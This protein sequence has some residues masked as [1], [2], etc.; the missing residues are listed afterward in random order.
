MKKVAVILGL[1][2]LGAAVNAEEAGIRLRFGLND[3]TPTNWDG[4][5]TVS[6]GHVTNI[7]GWRFT[8]ADS[9]DGYASWQ[10]ATRPA[11]GP[12]RANNPNA[13]P[14]LNL[15]ANTP[16]SDNGVLLS[17]A[18]VTDDSVVDV[19][20]TQGEFSFKLGDVAYGKIVDELDSAVEVERTASAVTLT[21]AKTDDDYPSAALA[22]DGTVFVAY[23][24]FT[25][26]LDR[27]QR[28]RRLESAPTD[29][30]FLS[31][32]PGGDQL[33]LR[34]VDGPRKG[35]PVAV[36]TTGHDIYKS[37]VAVDGSGTVWI[38][39][40]ENTAYQPFPNNPLPNFD[41]WA[42]PF[43]NGELGAPQQISS[44]PENDVW[45]VATTDAKGRV[46]VAW[47]GAR[48]QIF[49]IFERH[50]QGDGW[51]DERQVS[52]QTR[53][54]WAPAIAAASAKNGGRV[55][56]GWD[57]YDQGDYDVWLREF[58]ADAQ[59]ADARPV[60]NSPDYEARPALTY[61]Q[62]GSLWVAYELSGPSWGKDWGALVHD[63]GIPLYRDRQI[64]LAVLKDGQWEQP[65]H[66][67]ENALPGA[68]PRR[69]QLNQRAP[70]LEEGGESRQVAQEAEVRRNLPHNNIARIIT[71]ANGHV[72]IFARSR[73]ND[74]QSPLGSVWFNWATYYDG[75]NWVGPILVP[76]SDNLLY[77]VPAVVALNDGSLLITHS[78]DHRHDRTLQRV[79]L[80]GGNISLASTNDPYI[81]GLFLSRL[82]APGQV[83][84]AALEI[85]TNPP[86]ADKQP[87]A[88][89]LKELA[90][91]ARLRSYHVSVDGQDLRPV[92][93]EFHRHTEISGD[94]GNDGALEDM[95]RYA[96]D[97]ADFDW[98]GNGD[99]DNGAGRE[100]TWWLI[101]KTT[102]AFYL[103]D[104]FSPVYSYERSVPYPEGH[105][106]VIFAQRGIRTLPRLPITS[107]D[108][109]G[110]A[111][112]TQ[113]LY[114]YLH[115]Y[116]G[117]TAAHT[118]ATDMGTDWRDNDPEVEP[119]VEVYQGCRQNYERPGAPRS[120]T[121]D[122][123]IGGW[124]PKGFIN[125]ALQQKGYR[126]GFESSSDHGS[127]HISYA[128][129]YAKDN[130][131][132]EIIKA[133]KQ[134]HTYAA[135]ANILADV[136]STADGKEHFLGDEY[137]AS[138]S[139]KFSIKLTGT[140]PFAKVVIVKDDVEIHTE[141]PDSADVDFTW[142]DPSPVAGK[143]SYYYVR[144]E[145]KD[146]EL[147]WVSPQWVAY[148]PK[149]VSLNK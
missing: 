144:G 63:K 32:A 126:L 53:N 60:A 54:S 83:T 49:R 4:S 71:D 12:R 111:P 89:T 6:P 43:K 102:D 82:R 110:H 142:T 133:I 41:I 62:D 92:R 42:R 96:I 77:N 125:L 61:N 90:D 115:F 74:F 119:F 80:G 56:I 113:L 120:P 1:A 81:N 99:H 3:K 38:F 70:A 103:G 18:D 109:V 5:V 2:L 143:T 122:D 25:P 55:A 39:W 11:I 7:S 106:N 88:A 104:T 45:P 118:T 76:H 124:E 140:G 148:Q 66:G 20:T 58:D 127:T 57:T 27:D 101:Q 95:W 34:A 114:K 23:T 46:W 116:N 87:S 29:F 132:A 139:P 50:Q 107:R 28:A 65:V 59:P 147:V 79:G 69:R 137:T 37:A 84:E 16:I 33:W 97:V 78:S 130:T 136:R 30:T 35:E 15:G 129:I 98:I 19:K 145:Q 100:Y 68:I 117:V 14:R 47:Q 108:Y 131:K 40:S 105:R 85:S 75:Q 93:G 48:N 135:T 86:V 31:K 64:G 13:A 121:E 138:E 134:R 52:T 73:Q 72:W 24:S 149:T 112:D 44:A 141:T 67:F 91:V 51:S 26:G 8:A 10:A 17:F 22:A 123:A 21:D 9:T 36:T 146:G 128:I 94:G